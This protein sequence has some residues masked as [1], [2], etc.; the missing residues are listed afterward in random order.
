[1]AVFPEE[2]FE[3]YF[4][5]NELNCE[6][7]ESIERNAEN[8]IVE[9]EYE[10]H[11]GENEEVSV[12]QIDVPFEFVTAK[13]SN[14]KLLYTTIDK[15]LYRKCS[16]YKSIYSYRCRVSKCKSRVYYDL[17]SGNCF[18]RPKTFIS[19]NHRDQEDV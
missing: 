6:E 19:H 17:D 18:M 13:R 10:I 16:L 15:Y 7:N 3:E 9:E 11:I 4:D 5:E 12:S 2:N 8:E 1:M 14:G